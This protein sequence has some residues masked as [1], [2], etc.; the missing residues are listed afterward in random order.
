MSQELNQIEKRSF[1]FPKNVSVLQAFHLLAK[2][3]FKMRGY[4]WETRRNGEVKLGY[5]RKVLRKKPQKDAYPK[6]FVLIPGFGDSPLSW[7]I[8]VGLLQPVL[9]QSFDEVILVDF[10]GFGGFLS[11]EKAFPSFDLMMSVLNDTL[12]SLKPHTIIG[13]SLGA[14]M[15]AHYAVLCGTGVRPLSNR[16]NYSGPDTLML[17]NP[18]GLFGDEAT[19]EDWK[20]IFNQVKE[21]GFKILRPHLFV[22]E[23]RWFS[24]IVPDFRRFIKRDD[25]RLFM[26][27]FRED[28]ALDPLAKQIKSKVWLLWGEK[29]TLIPARCSAAWLRSLHQDE[30][31]KHHA[32]VLRNIGHSIHLERPT[33][34]AAIIGQ[35]ITN[36]I[37]HRMGGRWWKV[38][39]S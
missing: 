16:Q 18:S 27:T 33:V 37:P 31:K 21:E 34:T 13:H 7:A 24:W 10:P 12:D 8:V 19:K 2:A 23:P 5:W 6:R 30:N 4:Q 11:K 9:K 29:D 36:R 35:I 20:A 39:E 28:H 22:K 1:T 26:S 3:Y 32:I 38:I 25:I 14:W 17:A 15:V